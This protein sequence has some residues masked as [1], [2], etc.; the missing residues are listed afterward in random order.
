MKKQKKYIY[1]V[2]TIEY[3]KHK[4]IAMSINGRMTKAIFNNKLLESRFS[5]GC[6]VKD[7]TFL[8]ALKT[9]EEYLIC[10]T[11]EEAYGL[12]KLYMLTMEGL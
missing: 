9:T 3:R 10:D 2:Y 6:I 12:M 11:E 1:K 5:I 8:N 4:G 7:D